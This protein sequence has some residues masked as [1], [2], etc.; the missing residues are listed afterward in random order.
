MSAATLAEQMAR[1]AAENALTSLSI[2]YY[3]G[4]GYTSYFH[5]YAHAGDGV[6]GSGG[7][8]GD[9]PSEAIAKAIANL[10]EKRFPRTSVPELEAA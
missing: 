7:E 3:V 2:N 9:T 4:E 8:P 1:I 5:S 6:C 10:N